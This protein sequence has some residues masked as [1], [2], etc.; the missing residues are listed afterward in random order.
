MTKQIIDGGKIEVHLAGVLRLERAALEVEDNEAS[1]LQVIEEQVDSVF[2]L[3]HFE[4][5]LS[6]NER[7]A[8]SQL[9]EELLDVANKPGLYVSFV[10]ILR[11]A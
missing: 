9:K 1:K 8:D 10:S 6:A 5:H 2:L 3:G 11:R 4:R 7:E